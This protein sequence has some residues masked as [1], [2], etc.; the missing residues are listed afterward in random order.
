MGSKVHRGQLKTRKFYFIEVFG[1]AVALMCCWFMYIQVIGDMND[2]KC[3][4][5]GDFIYRIFHGEKGS[6][7]GPFGRTYPG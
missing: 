2:H 6:T 5:K 4:K 1:L 3:F 7:N